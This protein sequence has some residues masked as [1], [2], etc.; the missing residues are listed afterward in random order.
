MER[1]I[2]GKRERERER[3]IE[4][5]DNGKKRGERERERWN[6]RRNPLREQIHSKFSFV[7]T[8]ETYIN[9]FE[10]NNKAGDCLI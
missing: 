2:R 7:N 9:I 1:K 5:S 4:E 3:E 8:N 10:S 6:E